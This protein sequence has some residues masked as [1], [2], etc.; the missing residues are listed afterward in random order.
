[1]AAEKE[2]FAAFGIDNSGFE[3][4]AEDLNVLKEGKGNAAL[5]AISVLLQGDRNESELTA[6]L[7][8]LSVDLGDNG[9]WDNVK[10]RAQIA[11]WA[12][13]ADLE[14]RLAKIRANVEGWKLA[15]SAAPAFEQHVTNFW[16]QELGVDTCSSDNEGALF[17]VKNSHSTYYAA[18]DS[19]YT[20]GDS[21]LVRLI[22]AASGNSY[23]WRFATDS[24]KDVAALAGDADEGSAANGKVNTSFVYVK[25]NGSWRR[26]TEL[27]AS[28]YAACVADNKGLTDSLIVKHEPVWYICD[29]DDAASDSYAWREATTTEADTALFGTPGEGDPIVRIGNVNK[30]HTYVYE[31]VNGNGNAK[32]RYGTALDLDGGLGPCV[33]DKMN[34]VEQ[35]SGATGLKGWYICT[36]S[37]NS[38]EGT[39]IPSEWRKATDFER[40][41]YQWPDTLN[42]TLQVS[43]LSGLKYVFDNDSW[44]PATDFEKN[45]KLQACVEGFAGTIK[46]AGNDNE[47]WYK[48]TN[49]VPMTID[50]FNI[51]YTWRKASYVEID[52]AGLSEGETPQVGEIRKGRLTGDAYRYSYYKY[53]GS[54]WVMATEYEMDTYDPVLRAYWGAENDATVRQGVSGKY[55]VYDSLDGVWSVETS[56]LDH[57]YALGGCTRARSEYEVQKKEEMILEDEWGTYPN[58]MTC[59]FTES[60][61]QDFYGVHANEYFCIRAY[62]KGLVKQG[63]NGVDYLCIDHMWRK[64]SADRVATY[65]TTYLIG[66]RNS[67]YTVG[68]KKYYVEA[69]TF[70]L[71]NES[72]AWARTYGTGGG[73]RCGKFDESGAMTVNT[74]GT[75]WLCNKGY[76]EWDDAPYYQ[77][78]SLMDKT[79]YYT[80]PSSGGHLYNIVSIGNQIWLAQNI[81]YLPLTHVMEFGGETYEA[82]AASCYRDTYNGDFYQEMCDSLGGAYYSTDV[83][84]DVCGMLVPSVSNVSY[85]NF[86]LPTAAEWRVLLGNL[87]NQNRL[88][89]ELKSTINWTAGT[90]TDDYSFSVQPTGFYNDE[91]R[92]GSQFGEIAMYYTADDSV[93]VFDA[94]NNVTIASASKYVHGTGFHFSIY[95]RELM[96]PV[97]CVSD[98]TVPLPPKN[99]NK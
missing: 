79:D 43:K 86:H 52:T 33:M 24:E 41:T 71:E 67:V 29:K 90:G 87:K 64:A 13:K 2:L 36:E 75:R 38:V 68:G 19:A 61:C 72:E 81:K 25:E 85:G 7:A 94:S 45:D 50:G 16:M 93:V 9:Q 73:S 82:P 21:S 88:G 65:D 11:D 32:W 28:L 77:Y 92:Y 89:K 53:N 34:N 83:M 37:E 48:C 27:D 63:I 22:C 70:R 42:G 30:S 55:Y 47:G 3:G 6:L 97:R 39:R 80:N 10:Q 1:M 4:L 57:S 56:S 20:D 69:D 35:M 96:L 26:G 95:P 23:A 58:C 5:L 31:D 78:Q 62:A 44:R 51:P 15:E 17:A 18:N 12:M 49:E 66:S 74:I 84:Q 59:E 40:D 99:P 8:A 14:G 76:F 54:I 91:W 60:N 46:Q 98:L